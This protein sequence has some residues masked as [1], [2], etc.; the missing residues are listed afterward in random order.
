MKVWTFVAAMFSVSVLADQP[1][2]LSGTNGSPNVAAPAMSSPPPASRTSPGSTLRSEPLVPGQ[3]TVVANRVNVRGRAGLIGE[4]IGKL[5]NGE[6]VTVIEEVTLR[7][8]KP[9]EPS[10]WAKIA[11]PDS[12]AVWV[13]SGFVD[14][15]SMTVKANRLNLRGGPGE[16][17][18]V[19]GTLVRG[20][21][22]QE[23][24]TRGDWIQINAPDNAF[25]F[26]A[27]QYLRQDSTP[28]VATTLPED[29]A[30]TTLA[31]VTETPPVAT[32]SD[33]PSANAESTEVAQA[34][35][36]TQSEET[37]AVEE[38]LPPRIVQ[39]EGI[40]RSTLSIQAPTDFELVSTET[41][42]AIN[43]LF[44]SSPN[45]DLRRYK[46]LRILVTGEE[47]LDERWKNTPVLTIQQIRV[48]E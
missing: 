44:T 5:T 39:R 19:L 8:S 36:A 10:A 35:P 22:L 11:L 47:G 30:P 2:L 26:V 24:Q 15:S 40:V 23:L 12:I 33:Q 48:L 7:N 34:E 43:Y 18:S 28:Q 9:D 6:P 16:N 37:A 46:G 27:A 45:L 1:A 31:N 29:P 32:A 20:D 25:A 14:R 42:R 41:Y 3:A 13:H 17:Y 21:S 38:A 4:V